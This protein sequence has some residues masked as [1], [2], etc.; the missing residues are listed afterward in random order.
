M[1]VAE[2]YDNNNGLP[3]E[4]MEKEMAATVKKIKGGAIKSYPDWF[5]LI[6]VPCPPQDKMMELL[7]TSVNTASTTDG[8]YY[9]AG[10][11]GGGGRG[12]SSGGRGGGGGGGRGGRGRG[13]Y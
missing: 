3:T 12:G 4:E 1:Q 11:G 8:Y 2:R 5:Q 6:K 7:I 9:K 10:G 13:G